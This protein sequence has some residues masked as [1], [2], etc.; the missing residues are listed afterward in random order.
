MSEVHRV[1][2]DR[3]PSQRG[4]SSGPRYFHIPSSVL[5]LW[6]YASLLAVV[7]LTLL[8]Y[9]RPHAFPLLVL[10][11][12]WSNKCPFG[13]VINLGN[14]EWSD[15]VVPLLDGTSLCR[16]SPEVLPR[17]SH[18]PSLMWVP[19]WGATMYSPSPEE[20]VASRLTTS[21]RQVFTPGFVQC[22]H[23]PFR[24][25]FDGV[26]LVHAIKPFG[27]TSSQPPSTWMRVRG[28]SSLINQ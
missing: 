2:D 20:D 24:P 17:G 10:P 12:C 26:V 11:H 4:L 18:K 14:D 27:V 7:P 1:E 28:V 22:F 15:G 19:R 21:I 25:M 9:E 3:L 8:K 23:M 16:K 5:H 6:A 13:I